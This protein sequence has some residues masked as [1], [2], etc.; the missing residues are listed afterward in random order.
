MSTKELE[1]QKY[2]ISHNWQVK[3]QEFIKKFLNC[4][5]DIEDIIYDLSTDK[6]TLVTKNNIYEFKWLLDKYMEEN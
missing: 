2:L 6:I 1:M 3:P 5:Y 4:N